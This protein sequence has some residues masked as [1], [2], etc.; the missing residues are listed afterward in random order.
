VTYLLDKVKLHLMR[1]FFPH[2]VSS[3]Y[4]RGSHCST[5]DETRICIPRLSSVLFILHSIN[6]LPFRCHWQNGR[7]L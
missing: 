2:A 7:E 1:R 6:V 4:L 5:T 3:C